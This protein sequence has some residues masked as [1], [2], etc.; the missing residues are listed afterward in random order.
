MQETPLPHTLSYIFLLKQNFF[1][2]Q[3]FYGCGG[4]RKYIFALHRV[5][6]DKKQ[7]KMSARFTQSMTDEEKGIMMDGI[8]T[9]MN[10]LN[11]SFG[12]HN[13]SMLL[14]RNDNNNNNN[15]QQQQSFMLNI[16]GINNSNDNNRNQQMKQNREQILHQQLQKSMNMMQKLN[17]NILKI[18]TLAIADK[19]SDNTLKHYF[20][21]YKNIT[22]KKFELEKIEYKTKLHLSANFVPKN[23]RQTI[24]LNDRY[25]KTV[26]NTNFR[27]IQQTLDD[28]VKITLRNYMDK[29]I[30]ISNELCH[31]N[32]TRDIILKTLDAKINE[33]KRK[34]NRNELRWTS[35]TVKSAIYNNYNAEV[36]KLFLEKFELD[37]FYDNE[38]NK[39]KNKTILSFYKL[40][41]KIDLKINSNSNIKYDF[42]VDLNAAMVQKEEN[43][44]KEYDNH[45]KKEEVNMDVDAE[46]EW[47]DDVKMNKSKYD[48]SQCIFKQFNLVN[49]NYKQRKIIVENFG[50]VHDKFALCLQNKSNNR[51]RNYNNYK[52]QKRKYYYNK[53]N[54]NKRYQRKDF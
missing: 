49:V 40:A 4:D 37:E 43:K 2:R 46:Y 11:R 45:Y 5:L 7:N 35:Q 34:L 44:L 31:L 23:E 9:T 10:H 53:Y 51:K 26:N 28:A 27:Y 39:Y 41:N 6:Y 32:K 8:N 18:P 20:A 14:N 48:Q 54:K 30:S 12:N 52:N 21:E 13:D 22:K 50:N 19:L 1:A 3:K 38:L 17:E 15:Q 33:R 42:E 47:I 25:I 24:P 29:F 36:N 16:S